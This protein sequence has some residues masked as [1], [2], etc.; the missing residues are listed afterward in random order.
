M[1]LAYHDPK[2]L[3]QE[4]QARTRSKREAALRHQFGDAAELVGMFENAGLAVAPAKE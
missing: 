3:G 1:S 4:S 2:K